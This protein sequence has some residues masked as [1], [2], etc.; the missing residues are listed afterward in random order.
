MLRIERW[1]LIVA[2]LAGLRGV[3]AGANPCCRVQSLDRTTGVVT[4]SNTASGQTFQFRVSDPRLLAS[5]T[6]GQGVYANFKSN[7]VS[8]DGKTACCAIVSV[9]AGSGARMPESESPK[10][11][12][13]PATAP[14]TG[15]PP[16]PTP[17]TRPAENSTEG[18]IRGSTA[19][20]SN[21]APGGVVVPGVIHSPTS[22]NPD[23]AGE[24]QPLQYVNF[25]D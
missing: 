25:R 16:P 19:A 1:C 12:S 11:S 17:D 24:Q 6:V 18:A 22:S 2:L 10:A 5:L 14:I 4:A 23:I 15:R 13:R 7:Q 9:P 20:G 3:A 21:G 8:L